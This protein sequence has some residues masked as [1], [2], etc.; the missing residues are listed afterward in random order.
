MD[1][2]LSIST[3]LIKA[4]PR[5]IAFHYCANP[6]KA[7]LRFDAR[8]AAERYAGYAFPHS[9]ALWDECRSAYP[10]REIGSVAL[11][12]RR[13][14]LTRPWPG[15][16][17]RVRRCCFEQNDEVAAAASLTCRST[18]WLNLHRR[19]STPIRRNFHPMAA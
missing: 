4:V 10:E 3:Y 9:A 7:D 2:I 14:P 17:R 19:R 16:E 1:W 15:G 12:A 6:S 11:E 18:E 8:K 13:E 5:R